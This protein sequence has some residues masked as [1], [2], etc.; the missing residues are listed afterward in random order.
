MYLKSQPIPKL[1]Y[2][3]KVLTLEEQRAI[4]EQRME[5][6]KIEYLATVFGVANSTI[7]KVIK[8]MQDGRQIKLPP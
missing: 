2:K 3:G 5:G 8:R 7:V 4:Y 1:K 6:M